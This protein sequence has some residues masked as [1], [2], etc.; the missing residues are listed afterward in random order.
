MDGD[1]DVTIKLLNEV[2]MSTRIKYPRTLYLPWSE[3]KGDKKLKADGMFKG[4]EVVVTE[5]L[6]GENTSITST[7]WHARSTTPTRHWSRSYIG[8]LQALLCYKIDPYRICG[9]NM[10]AQHTIVYDKLPAYFIVHSLWRDHY[11]LPWSQTVRFAIHL[12]L[13]HVPVLY[14]GIYDPKEIQKT[15]DMSMR[16]SAYST[17]E[18]SLEGY[19]IRVSNG[20]NLEDFSRC[21]G[22]YVYSDFRNKIDEEETHWLY[23]S[24]TPNILA[25]VK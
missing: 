15:V 2:T 24:H 23:K 11:C 7:Y 4:M 9:E 12:D 14:K 22:K 20:F 6:D 5:K 17:H 3:G 10:Y 25:R 18:N 13:V 8:Q 1:K 21:V 19:V 16:K